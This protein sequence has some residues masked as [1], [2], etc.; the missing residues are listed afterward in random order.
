MK[1]SL[2]LLS[3]LLFLTGIATWQYFQIQIQAP[4][5]AAKKGKACADFGS[6]A[7]RKACE[8]ITGNTKSKDP[9]S[10]YQNEIVYMNEEYIL[11]GLNEIGDCSSLTGDVTV[12]YKKGRG[13]QLDGKG[14]QTKDPL[15]GDAGWRNGK[16]VG[17]FCGIIQVDDGHGHFCS[18]RDMNG[19]VEEEKTA[20]VSPSPSSSPSPSPNPSLSPSPSPSPSP[21]P[22][23]TPTP[24]PGHAVLV[25]RKFRDDD[26]DGNWDTNEG[27][28]GREWKFQ[29]RISSDPWQDYTVPGDRD[30]GNGVDISLGTKVEVREIEQSGWTNT[31]GLTKIEILYDARTYYFDFGN[32]EQPGVT[33]TTAPSVAPQAGSGSN[34]WQ[35]LALAGIGLALQLTALL[36]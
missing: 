20:Q 21:L 13:L 6:P 32:F 25:I 36:L 12:Y 7:K 18:R 9:N 33:V 14:V 17:S 10:D 24:Q 29:Y 4:V 27:R 16:I 5:D 23:P 35:W 34:Y 1:K 28:T 26:R 11:P 15:P 3:L 2:V 30:Y 31:S 19:C 22:S 8:E